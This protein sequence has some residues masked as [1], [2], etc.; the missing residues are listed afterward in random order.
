MVNNRLA[1][2]PVLLEPF[3]FIYFTGVENLLFFL[4]HKVTSENILFITCLS[5]NFN[6]K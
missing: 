1:A 5:E 3:C 2:L 6:L 4:M